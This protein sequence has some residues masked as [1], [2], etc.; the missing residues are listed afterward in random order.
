[1]NLNLPSISIPNLKQSLTVTRTVTNV[2]PVNSVYVAHVQPPARVSVRVHPPRLVFNSTVKK[3]K[4]KVSFCTL[5]R[6]QGRYSF[7][8]LFW[9]DGVHVV[10]IPLVVRIV[11]RESL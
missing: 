11:I 10:R 2:G 5:I 8:N 6:T 1:M 3:L 7:G 4:F 9:E